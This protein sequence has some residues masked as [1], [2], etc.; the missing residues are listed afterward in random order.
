LQVVPLPC[1]TRTD[2]ICTAKCYFAPC[3]VQSGGCYRT[4][5][6]HFLLALRQPHEYYSY[7]CRV[8]RGRTLPA[9]QGVILPL[10]PCLVQSLGS[11]R[12]GMDTIS[13]CLAPIPEVL[14]V[15]H[16][17]Y[18][19]RM[20][21]TYH[22]DGRYPHGKVLFYSSPAGLPQPPLLLFFLSLFLS[23]FLSFFFF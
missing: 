21:C 11:Y 2:V 1:A 10:A 23:F 18:L 13:D 9:R 20:P 19:P 16:A 6:A 8:Q 12:H 14:F 3:R 7:G 22:A 4:A 15:R 17:V 5:W